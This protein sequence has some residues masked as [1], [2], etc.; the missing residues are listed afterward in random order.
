MLYKQ[1]A[2]I[3]KMNCPAPYLMRANPVI[4][5]TWIEGIGWIR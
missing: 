5:K 3:W 1:A 4:Y 2:V